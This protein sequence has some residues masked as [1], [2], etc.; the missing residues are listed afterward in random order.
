MPGL[1]ETCRLTEANL[2]VRGAA[3]GL[4]LGFQ[5]LDGAL[6]PACKRCFQFF[7]GTPFIEGI[8]GFAAFG[9][10]NVTAGVLLFPTGC[11]HKVN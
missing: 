5:V 8:H 7:L 1:G 11:R 4:V 3:V 2:S 9:Q 10:M 6:Q